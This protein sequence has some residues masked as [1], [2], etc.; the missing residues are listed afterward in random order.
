MKKELW[1]EKG[2]RTLRFEK[3][4]AYPHCKDEKAYCSEEITECGAECHLVKR[5]I[6]V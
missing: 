2:T 4:S 6:R 5:F 1:I 3:L